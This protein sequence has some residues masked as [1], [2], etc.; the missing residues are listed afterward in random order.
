QITRRLK[1]KEEEVEG[2]FPGLL[3]F[4]DCTEQPIP[5]PTKNRQK[6]DRTTLAR[7]RNTRT[8]G[9]EPVHS[10]P[11]G[12]S[13]YKNTN[14]STGKLE[15]NTTTTSTKTIVLTSQRM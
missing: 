10:K 13:I 4:T 3:V 6:R 1:T 11:K 15:R 8:H 9:Q 7:E 12:L 2:Y 14:P 5:G